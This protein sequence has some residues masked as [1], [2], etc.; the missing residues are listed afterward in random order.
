MN[1][2]SKKDENDLS[3]IEGIKRLNEKIKEL[4]NQNITPPV[5]IEEPTGLLSGGPE[6]FGLNDEN[7]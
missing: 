7:D 6:H 1:N 2:T 5:D 3:E 4:R